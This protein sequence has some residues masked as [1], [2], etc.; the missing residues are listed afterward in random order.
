MTTALDRT[1]RERLSVHLAELLA[2]LQSISTWPLPVARWATLWDQLRTV[3]DTQQTRVACAIAATV[4]VT[5]THGDLSA[6]NILVTADGDLCA[7]IDWDGATL[8]D[9]AQDYSALCA[10]VDPQLAGMLRDR[11]PSADVL[12]RRAD[13]YL[14]TWPVQHDLWR[15]GRHPWF[16]GVESN[17]PGA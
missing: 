17:Q 1:A 5:L 2:A 13:A 6:G 4:R 12:Q 14:A 9:P 3:A 11:V 8:A 10:N 15:E 7:V 16:T